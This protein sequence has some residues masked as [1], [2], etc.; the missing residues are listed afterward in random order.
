MGAEEAK[1]QNVALANALAAE[2]SQAEAEEPKEQTFAEAEIDASSQGAISDVPRPVRLARHNRRA[3]AAVSRP[4]EPRSAAPPPPPPSSSLQDLPVALF[5][6]CAFA[7]WRRIH[8]W[9]RVAATCRRAARALARALPGDADTWRRWVRSLTWRQ[10]KHIRRMHCPMPVLPAFSRPG[11]QDPR[12]FF[13]LHSSMS[14]DDIWRRLIQM[15]CATTLG[16]ELLYVSL[17][18]GTVDR[19]HVESLVT[20]LS[21]LPVH[22]SLV[23]S[24]RGMA[25]ALLNPDFSFKAFAALAGGPVRFGQGELTL[26]VRDAFDAVVC[27]RTPKEQAQL[28]AERR[29]KRAEK[30]AASRSL[31]RACGHNTDPSQQCPVCGHQPAPAQARHD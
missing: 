22:T 26:E 20:A 15:R 24:K 14:G 8:K 13:R 10:R 23:F 5:Q 2:V 3:A 6:R 1:E 27:R 29:Q 18:F 9:S 7:G 17:A 28:M 11:G 25:D 31:P 30:R 12:A 16:L 19:A 4:L 21:G